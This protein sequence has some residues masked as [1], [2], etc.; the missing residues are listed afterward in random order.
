MLGA[1]LRACGLLTG[2]GLSAFG[3]AIAASAGETPHV[4]PSPTEQ[5]IISYDREQRSRAHWLLK[6][7]SGNAKGSKLGDAS[8]LWTVPTPHL[9]RL[10]LQ[11]RL[12]GSKITRLPRIGTIF[13]SA[14]PRS[15]FPR[16]RTR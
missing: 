12:V 11:L 15:P 3:L 2:L 6:S 4:N 14:T 13:S 9:K 5:G 7:I 8:E 1:S 16:P 10:G